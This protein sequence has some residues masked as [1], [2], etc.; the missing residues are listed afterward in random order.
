MTMRAAWRHLIVVA[1]AG[2]LGACGSTPNAPT[3]IPLT[4]TC[5]ANVAVQ[6]PDGNA[7][8]ATFEAPVAD[9]SVDTAWDAWF[10]AEALGLGP[11]AAALPAVPLLIR[12][13]RPGE[14]M[15]PFGGSRPVR[16]AKLLAASGV[17]RH[18]RAPWPVLTR[19][20]GPG[21]GE[22]LWLLGIRRSAVA[23]ITARTRV[24]LHL[25]RTPGSSPWEG[26]PGPP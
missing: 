11:V 5:P 21:D 6:S 13:R 19:A 15:I 24:A 9:R 20:G 3:P 8:T 23:P 18:A 12:P 2:W 10:D 4:I 7:V 14:R 26:V 1:V 16:L 25:R 17:P 22:I